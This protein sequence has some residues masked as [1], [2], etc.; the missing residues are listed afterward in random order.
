MVCCSAH[1]MLTAKGRFP[2]VAVNTYPGVHPAKAALRHTA[3][4]FCAP[5]SRPSFWTLTWVERGSRRLSQNFHFTISGPP[6]ELSPCSDPRLAQQ[7]GEPD[8]TQGQRGRSCRPGAPGLAFFETLDDCLSLPPAP[9]EGASPTERMECSQAEA[10]GDDNFPAVTR[11]AY[12]GLE[13]REI[14]AT[15]QT[16]CSIDRSTQ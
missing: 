4:R 7:K 12:P 16:S 14:W 10:H 13:R 6:L 9:G 8:G 3:H 15:H 11:R 1:S 5:G 2:H